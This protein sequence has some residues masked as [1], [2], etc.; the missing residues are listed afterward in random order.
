MTVFLDTPVNKSLGATGTWTDIDL[1]SDVPA[2]ATGAIFEVINTHSTSCYQFGLRKKGSTDNIYK[3]IYYNSHIFAIIGIDS[4]RKCQGKIE[5][6]VMNF[7]L[8]GYT[9]EDAAFFTN[10]YDKSQ[11]TTGAWTDLDLSSELPAGSVAAIF[12]IENVNASAA[13][14]WGLRKKGSSDERYSNVTNTFQM[15]FIIGV[16]TN[17][18]CQFKIETVDIN[19]YLVGYLSLGASETNGVDRSIGSTGSYVDITESNAPSDATGAFGETASS[20]DYSWAVRKNGSSGDFYRKL[21]QYK[22][23]IFVGLDSSKKWEGKIENTG[24]D[25]YT[26]GYFVAPSVKSRGHGYI[27]G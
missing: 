23:G 19:F 10:A 12:Q 9:E 20:G 1:S 3:H 11:T 15:F 22:S 18:K 5:S 7:H 21:S 8:V 27:F 17:R 16:D 13:K 24:L 26:L 2:S 25:F 14:S 6:T 4:N